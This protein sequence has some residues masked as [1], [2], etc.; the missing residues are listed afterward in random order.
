LLPHGATVRLEFTP[1]P[2]GRVSGAQRVKPDPGRESPQSI[3]LLSVAAR[4]CCHL[5]NTNSQI[6]TVQDSYPALSYPVKS[7]LATLPKPATPPNSFPFC[8]TGTLLPSA[9]QRSARS[10]F[11]FSRFDFPLLQLSPLSTAFT[12][13]RF[14]TPLST[15]F[16]QIT[17][18]CGGRFLSFQPSTFDCPPPSSP[19]SSRTRQCHRGCVVL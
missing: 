9:F 2:V 12:P 17:R 7:S 11:R 8:S 19:A 10:E 4:L 5:V 18:G 13:N 6:G 16:T 1:V 14:L 15:A 3:H